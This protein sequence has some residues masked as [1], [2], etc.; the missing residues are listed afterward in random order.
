MT[1][2]SDRVLEK[3]LGAI[4]R[5]AD[6]RLFPADVDRACVS[7]LARVGREPERARPWMA[8]ASAAAVLLAVAI[9]AAGGARTPGGQERAPLAAEIDPGIGDLAGAAATTREQAARALGTLGIH[10]ADGLAAPEK[11]PEHLYLDARSPAPRGA[12][13]LPEG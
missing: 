5:A 4:L 8:L 11:L 13:V 1:L 7:F 2:P 9:W 6:D 12:G 3:N 10:L